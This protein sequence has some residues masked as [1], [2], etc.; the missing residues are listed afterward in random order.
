MSQ[1]DH[2]EHHHH[3]TPLKVYHG[4]FIALLF[5]TVITVWISRFDCHASSKC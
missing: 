3:I 2:A 4:I 5:L 1:H